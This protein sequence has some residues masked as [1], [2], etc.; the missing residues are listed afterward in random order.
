MRAFLFLLLAL[1]SC[2][3]P[4]KA[5]LKVLRETRES[6]NSPVVLKAHKSGK[7]TE[8]QLELRENNSFFYQSRVAGSQKSVIYAGTFTKKN[9]TLFLSFQ[10]NHKDSL[11]TGEAIMDTITNEITFL[12]KNT[13][14]N[15]QLPIV[16]RN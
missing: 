8:D 14:Y 9:D 12:S 7:E 13:N 5:S 16:K 11:W 1:A 15:K 6:R 4:D 10:D 3:V 2:T